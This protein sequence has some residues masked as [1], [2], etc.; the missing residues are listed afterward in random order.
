MTFNDWESDAVI[1]V[2]CPEN[3]PQE[4]SVADVDLPYDVLGAVQFTDERGRQRRRE[5]LHVRSNQKDDRSQQAA[6]EVCRYLKPQAI[7]AVGIAAGDDDTKQA[8]GD[9]LVAEFSLDYE[10]GKG[11]KGTIAPRP[12][13]AE[14]SQPWL[15]RFKLI[16]VKAQNQWVDND[17]W[18]QFWPTVRFGPVA[19][20]KKLL[21][22]PEYTAQLR[23]RCHPHK[24]IG[25]EME[26]L[27]LAR[28]VQQQGNKQLAVEWGLVKAISDF[29]DG[30]KDENKEEYQR[31]AALRAARFVYSALTGE[32][33]EEPLEAFPKS[34]PTQPAQFSRHHAGAKPPLASEFTAIDQASMI[35]LQVEAV[36]CSPA[37]QSLA[38]QHPALSH[39]LAWAD[40]ESGPPVYALLGGYGMGKTVTCQAFADELI[41]RR[42]RGEATRWP[43]Y[44]DLRL[45]SVNWN[46]P[47]PSVAEIM[48]RCAQNGWQRADEVTAR[49]IWDIIDDGAVVIFDGLDEV[50]TSLDEGPGRDFI[51][52]LFSVLKQPTKATLPPK[53]LISSRPQYFRTSSDERKRLGSGADHLIMSRLIPLDWGQIERYLSVTFPPAELYSVMELL[54]KIHDLPDLAQKPYMLNLIRNDLPRIIKDW[55]GG[56]AITAYTLYRDFASQWLDRDGRKSEM[57]VEHKFELSAHIARLMMEPQYHRTVLAIPIK[58]LESWFEDWRQ[59][60]PGWNTYHGVPFKILAEDLRNSTFLNRSDYYSDSFEFAHRSWQEFFLAE[61]ML[62]ALEDDRPD[63]WQMRVP[64]NETQDFLGQSMLEVA[65][66]Q[67]PRTDDGAVE[68]LVE[69][70]QRW[71]LGDWARQEELAVE[72]KRQEQAIQQMNNVL[73]DHVIRSRVK[74]WP[75]QVVNPCPVPEMVLSKYRHGS[76]AEVQQ[77]LL[78]GELGIGSRVTLG[79]HVW[80]VLDRRKDEDLADHSKKE[81][82]LLVSEFVVDVSRPYQDSPE[83]I[84]WAECSLRG[85]LNREFFESLDRDFSDQI[86]TTE[87]VTKGSRP[88]RTEGGEPVKDSLFLLSLEEVKNKKLFSA[89]G[90]RQATRPDNYYCWWWLRSPGDS[91]GD[92]AVVNNLGKILADGLSVDYGWNYGG[93]VRPALWLN[94][95]S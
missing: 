55:M 61:F 15:K 68:T 4:Q 27:G 67:F 34:E 32:Y 47:L 65:G 54:V 35:E 72:T 26:G 93:G 44:F 48:T 12:E 63:L 91:Q 81:K 16:N 31:L 88:N 89:E 75:A 14:A 43:L 74:G 40:D 87:V 45:A 29:G 77:A 17:K 33:L 70:L 73:A 95:D 37:G 3:V 21:N 49:D 13:H 10:S 53:V 94:L 51:T 86:A 60:Q 78:S 28:A 9:V 19:T 22:D 7:L 38:E 76:V 2:F 85:W 69:R 57:S 71:A 23:E 79:R 11:E 42:E 36:N 83:G 58:Q 6:S 62:Q 5:V 8:V 80:R 56:R 25:Y 64:S 59:K 66:R 50:L 52:R 92:A 18:K 46:L 24:P 1:K 20:G 41:R 39:L 82:A 30:N 90:E 84:T